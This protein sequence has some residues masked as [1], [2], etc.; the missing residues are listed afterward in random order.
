MSYANILLS[1]AAVQLLAAA[2]P[3]PT[4][5]IVSRY[6]IGEPRARTFLVVGGVLLADLGWAVLAA[7]GLGTL[8]LRYPSTYAVL[9][10]AGAAYLIWLGGKMLLVVAPNRPTV[11]INGG[12][13]PIFAGGA[14][15]AGFLANMINPKS[16]AYYTSLFVVMIPA[17]PP[18][19]L[20]A[21][22]IGTAL[23]VS[24]A[25]WIAVALFFAMPPVRAVYERA[26]RS[27]EAI[28][29]GVLVCLGVRLA[30]SR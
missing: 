23:L 28:M 16:I 24:T 8:I 18:I 17:Q 2:S 1:I 7:C 15:R 30:L 13:R 4:F 20:F 10:I 5:V 29:G 14:I 3:G 12:S 26:R 21:A 9:Q 27:I 6:S 22:V 19:W 25:W 11:L